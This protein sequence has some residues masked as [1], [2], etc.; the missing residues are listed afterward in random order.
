MAEVLTHW[1]AL[2]KAKPAVFK[3][4]WDQWTDLDENGHGDIWLADQGIDFPES[5]SVIRFRASLYDRAQRVTRQRKK[6]APTV[7]K[8]VTMRV[9]GT[10]EL[11]T[12]MKRVHQ[13]TVLKVKVKMVSDTQ[14]A[15]Q[16]YEGDEPPAEPEV[17]RVAI[18]RRRPLRQR[19]SPVAR[20]EKV[21]A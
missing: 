16:F 15:F 3:Y 1:P 19:T 7:L 18:P 2:R 14:V 12:R 17:I 4:P 6:N 9:K 11:V 13:Y 20:L 8:P 21:G 5:S 10:D